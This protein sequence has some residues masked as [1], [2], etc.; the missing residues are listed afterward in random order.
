M[1]WNGWDWK[2]NSEGQPK[3]TKDEVLKLIHENGIELAGEYTWC[4]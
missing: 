3:V 2:I 4:G 1:K